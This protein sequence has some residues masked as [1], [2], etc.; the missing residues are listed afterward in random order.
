MYLFQVQFLLY[1]I[2]SEDYSFSIDSKSIS[3]EIIGSSGELAR[4]TCGLVAITS[5]SYAEGRQFDPSQIYDSSHASSC[6]PR[7]LSGS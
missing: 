2:H 7:R 4:S 5:A 1:K 6:S 3:N